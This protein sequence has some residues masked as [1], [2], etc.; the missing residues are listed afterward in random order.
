MASLATKG[1]QVTGEERDGQVLRR[2]G[3]GIFCLAAALALASC[4]FVAKRV[5]GHV[6]ARTGPEAGASAFRGSSRIANEPSQAWPVVSRQVFTDPN[7]LRAL[8]PT[9]PLPFDF[10]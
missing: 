5:L 6:V 4:G 10:A 7:S 9:V 3:V 8:L 1:L 2:C